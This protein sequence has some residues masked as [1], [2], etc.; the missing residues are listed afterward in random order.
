MSAIGFKMDIKSEKR[1]SILGASRGYQGDTLPAIRF[2]M[3]YL[4]KIRGLAG[5]VGLSLSGLGS[6][7]DHMA[8]FFLFKISQQIWLL[9]PSKV[10]AKMGRGW[11]A[12]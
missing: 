7:D 1:G 10:S 6:Y 5:W 2:K 4:G 12:D 8:F 11:Q 3:E 9:E